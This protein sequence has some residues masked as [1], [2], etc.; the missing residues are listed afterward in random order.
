[1]SRDGFLPG[2]RRFLKW[3]PLAGLAHA[4]RGW[5]RQGRRRGPERA[6]RARRHRD[7]CLYD[8]GCFLHE[9]DARFVAICDVKTE[10]R[11]AAKEVAYAKY[12]NSDRATYVDPRQ[13]CPP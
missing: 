6:D 9:P 1:M 10:H 7:L 12:G 13:L 5:S 3:G 2:R 4:I 8:L 11:K